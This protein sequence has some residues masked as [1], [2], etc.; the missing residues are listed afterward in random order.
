M[1]TRYFR[2]G[3]LVVFLFFGSLSTLIGACDSQ[4]SLPAPQPAQQTEDESD[5]SDQDTDQ[6]SNDQDGDTDE[7]VIISESRAVQIMGASCLFAG[8]HAQAQ[9]L[10]D[11]PDKSLESLQNRTMPPPDQ[12]RYSISADRR[13]QLM[14]FFQDRL[15]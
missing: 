2:S 10:L 9:E 1:L 4:E 13:N 8:C 3:F 7:V 5:D 6:D 12:T 11:Q 14:A 15:N